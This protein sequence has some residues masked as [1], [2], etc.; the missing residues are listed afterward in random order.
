MYLPGKMIQFDSYF[1]NGLV[2]PPTSF[3]IYTE[4]QIL[5]S[6]SLDVLYFSRFGELTDVYLPSAPGGGTGAQGKKWKE[7]WWKEGCVA[8][9]RYI[10]MTVEV[11][12]KECHVF[13]CLFFVIM[14]VIEIA[15]ITAMVM[16]VMMAMVMMRITATWV[17]SYAVIKFHCSSPEASSMGC[18]FPA[19]IT[20][21]L[22]IMWRENSS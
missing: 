16:V 4:E 12:F 22:G 8:R 3:I 20:T 1:S 17:I 21:Q 19:K 7:Q 15:M 6:Q 9:C 14:I 5:G 10:P 11:K 13:D 2:Q 18:L